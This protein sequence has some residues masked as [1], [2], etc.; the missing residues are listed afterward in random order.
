MS[1]HAEVELGETHLGEER[2]QR[3]KLQMKEVNLLWIGVWLR[4]LSECFLATLLAPW[5][6]I[7]DDVS[8]SRFLLSTLTSPLLAPIT[9]QLNNE[10]V[11]EEIHRF[12][13]PCKWEMGQLGSRNG[14]SGKIRANLST[15]HLIAV[16]RWGAME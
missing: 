14:D 12:D 1:D 15:S 9:F 4:F 7:I 11:R 3:Q 8:D 6:W 5:K 13:F 2:V 10:E 16:S